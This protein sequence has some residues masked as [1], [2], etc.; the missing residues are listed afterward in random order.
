MIQVAVIRLEHVQLAMPAGGE[1]DAVAFYEGL[2]GIP[3]VPKPQ[4]LAARGGCWFERT[5]LKVHLGVEEH[6]RPAAKAHPAFLVHDVRA[7]AEVIASAGFTVVDD[8]PLDGYDRI[9]V[10]DPFG[11]RI[12][13]MQPIG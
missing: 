3:H 1:A 5:D 7:L 9:Y 12:E 8:Q 4:H 10:H 6:F 2:L 13:L 11:N